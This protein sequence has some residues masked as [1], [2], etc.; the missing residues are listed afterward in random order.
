[1]RVLVLDTSVFV[2]ALLG[3]GGASR[4]VLRRCLNAEYLPLMGEALY[5]EH[6]AVLSREQKFARCALPSR[7]R[8]ELLDAYLRVCRWTKV[9][10]LWRPNLPDESDNH[11][12]E[13]AMAGGAEVIVIKNVRD[14]RAGEL[15]FPGLRIL[16]PEQLLKE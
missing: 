14:I 9:Y 16:K 8:A 5:A 2:S 7:E 15:K 1:M 3:P 10:F 6:E 11:L 13:L 4:E 12:V